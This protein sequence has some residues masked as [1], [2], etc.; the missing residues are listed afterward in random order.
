MYGVKDCLENLN[1]KI[2][3]MNNSRIVYIGFNYFI[4]I[5]S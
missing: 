2:L 4:H 1:N 5:D 3:F